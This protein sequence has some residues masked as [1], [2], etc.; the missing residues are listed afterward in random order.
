MAG[1][2]L[3]RRPR[4]FLGDGV[5]GIDH[6][7]APDDVHHGK[8]ARQ[9]ADAQTRKRIHF[10]K[11]AEDHDIRIAA[12]P[13]H[14]VGVIFSFHEF[15]IGLVDDHDLSAVNG[16]EKVPEDFGCPIC[17]GGIV[18][19]AEKDDLG[20]AVNGFEHGRLVE[21]LVDQRNDAG[22]DPGKNGHPLIDRKGLV[23][24]DD[25]VALF[26]EGLDDECDHLVGA[27]ADED[28][29]RVDAVKGRQFPAQIIGIAARVDGAGRRGETSDHLLG[30]RG[31]TQRVFVVVEAVKPP[32]AI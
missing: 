11:G 32:A 22:L 14:A 2:I 13:L 15:E 23:R 1:G 4:G 31:R 6:A 25:V 18:R 9:V 26:A 20:P 10:G 5:D 21:A 17:S 28:L 24:G 30:F 3:Q 27:V 12:D 7:G 29:V 19:V 8:I 16:V